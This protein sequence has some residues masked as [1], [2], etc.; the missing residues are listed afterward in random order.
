MTDLLLPKKFSYPELLSRTQ[1]T[2]VETW[3]I[4]DEKKAERKILP[5]FSR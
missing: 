1:V 3:I 2:L 5:A 4:T